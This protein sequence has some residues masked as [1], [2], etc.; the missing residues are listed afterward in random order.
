M[1]KVRSTILGDIGHYHYRI[2]DHRQIRLGYNHETVAISRHRILV[3]RI[4]LSGW[5]DFMVL[6][7]EAFILGKS[8]SLIVFP[9]FHKSP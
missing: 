6:L 1:Q 5:M 9:F 2:L 4:R 8:S 7:F 3:S